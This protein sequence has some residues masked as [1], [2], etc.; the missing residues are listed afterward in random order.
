[1]K[2]TYIDRIKYSFLY[3]NNILYPL[4]Y[5]LT[6]LF[7]LCNILDDAFVIVHYCVLNYSILYSLWTLFYNLAYSLALHSKSLK[8]L[9]SYKRLILLA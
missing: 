9:L 4:V 3:M 7:F 5:N 8:F 6:S 1:M 2:L